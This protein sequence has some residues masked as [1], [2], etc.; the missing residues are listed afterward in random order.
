M[1]TP[2]DFYLYQG[3]GNQ[4]VI[5]TLRACRKIATANQNG[6]AVML[7]AIEP[8]IA[9]GTLPGGVSTT[10]VGLSRHGGNA[11]ENLRPGDVGSAGV[12]EV[13]ELGGGKLGVGLSPTI[14]RANVYKTRPAIDSKGA[15]IK[16]P[17]AAKAVMA[18]ILR[19]L[20]EDGSAKT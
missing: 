14:A 7:V 2:P 15:V 5:G 3:E 20:G 19:A 13:Y 8:A 12:W 6:Q 1:T 10:V 4:A 11:L 9:A 16:P 17:A 18:S